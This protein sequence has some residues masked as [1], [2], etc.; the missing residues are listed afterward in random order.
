MTTEIVQAQPEENVAEFVPFG[1]RDVIRLSASMVKNFIASPTKSGKLPEFRDCVKFVMLC[2]AKKLNPY[3]GDAYL[4][5]YD[6]D[7]GPTFSLITAHQAFL[8]RAESNP[9]FDGLDS[10]VTVEAKHDPNGDY[11]NVSV[12]RIA[13]GTIAYERSG[14]FLF[15]D[16]KILGAWGRVNFRTRKTPMFKRL[17]LETFDKGYSQWKSN[18]AGMIVKCAEADCLRSSFPTL[19]GGLYIEGEMQTREERT[20]VA[21]P[22]ALTTTSEPMPESPQ[23]KTTR[24]KREPHVEPAMELDPES[25]VLC[26]SCKKPIDRDNYY[27]AK[28]GTLCC[29]D[30]CRVKLD[31]N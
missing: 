9:E 14:D 25:D 22:R 7:A 15:P 21:M 12:L 24:K 1:S 5:G 17:R 26:P 20:P 11:S 8:K 27:T 23:P 18:K 16:E 31:A 2:K 19:L 29:S 4:V 3:E 10:G 28:D 6:G 30:E 13:D